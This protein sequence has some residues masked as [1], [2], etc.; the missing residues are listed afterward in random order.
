MPIA[1]VRE[2]KLEDRPERGP[3]IREVGL[4]RFFC[5]CVVDVNNIDF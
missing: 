3:D 5:R 1:M 4:G 2:L